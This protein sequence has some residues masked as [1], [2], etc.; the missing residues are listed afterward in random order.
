MVEPKFA[1]ES[2]CGFVC[3]G[4]EDALGGCRG[5]GRMRRLYARW[6]ARTLVTSLHDPGFA[7]DD[8]RALQEHRRL[9]RAAGTPCRRPVR[10]PPAASE[11]GLRTAARRG[12]TLRGGRFVRADG[13]VTARDPA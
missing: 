6:L 9:V 1:I 5:P 3:E 13:A 10:N 8:R 7:T 11:S 2:G 4:N 12:A